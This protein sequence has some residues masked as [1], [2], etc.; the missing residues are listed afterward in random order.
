MPVHKSEEGWDR[1]RGNVRS[2]RY[3]AGVRAS[4]ME[5]RPRASFRAGKPRLDRTHVVRDQAYDQPELVARSMCGLCAEVGRC[6]QA[7]FDTE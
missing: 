5:H 7:C 2:R 1:L 3:K 4:H 6:T